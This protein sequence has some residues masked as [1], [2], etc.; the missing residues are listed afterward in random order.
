MG[1]RTVSTRKCRGSL[2]IPVKLAAFPLSHMLRVRRNKAAIGQK[3]RTG[4]RAAKNQTSG[5]AFMSLESIAISILGTV[6]RAYFLPIEKLLNLAAEA[7]GVE[8]RTS[9]GSSTERDARIA[10]IDDAKSNLKEAIIAL[11][12]LKAEAQRNQANLTEALAKL[13]G[14]KAQHSVERDQL[15]KIRSIAQADIDAFR[16]MAGIQSPLKERVIG[17]AGGV[18]ASLLAAGL[19]KLGETIL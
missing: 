2:H 9:V 6:G 15:E 1:W 8:V 7:T 17:F 12:E 4:Q 3:R 18:V 11:D 14:V 16:R 5:G 10:K 13:S 19:W